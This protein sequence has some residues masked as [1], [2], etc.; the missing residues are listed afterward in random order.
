VRNVGPM[1][2][3]TRPSRYRDDV[4]YGVMTERPRFNRSIPNHNI[5]GTVA[6]NFKGY[7]RP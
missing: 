1:F 3:A 6:M 2:I 5:A 7:K 4:A